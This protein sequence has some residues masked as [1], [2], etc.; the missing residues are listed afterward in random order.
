MKPDQSF[1]CLLAT[2][3]LGVGVLTTSLRAADQDPS[4]TPLPIPPTAEPIP[5]TLQSPP[6]NASDVPLVK[7]P[8]KLY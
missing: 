7:I 4:I 1:L 3:A 8:K 5:P 2:A 6:P